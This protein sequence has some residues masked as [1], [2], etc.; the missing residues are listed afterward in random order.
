MVENGKDS[1]AYLRYTDVEDGAGLL[2]FL[3]NSRV[4]I[5][6]FFGLEVSD[7]LWASYF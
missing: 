4:V 2:G 6:F 3:L 5:H 1:L 7:D